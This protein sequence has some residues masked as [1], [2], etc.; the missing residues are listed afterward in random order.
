M[1]H[2]VGGTERRVRG[3]A[4]TALLAAAFSPRGAIS[5]SAIVGGIGAVLL[6]TALLR[7]CP[8]NQLVGRD[9]G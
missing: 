1:T 3:A 7:Y 6:A 9:S 8:L 4:G 5:R 2:N